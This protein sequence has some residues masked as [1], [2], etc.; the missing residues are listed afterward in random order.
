MLVAQSWISLHVAPGSAFSTPATMI[1]GNRLGL[2]LICFP[3]PPFARAR[4]LF[5]FPSNSHATFKTYP[6]PQLQ[7]FTL[8]NGTFSVLPFLILLFGH[9][10]DQCAF[11]VMFLF[12]CFCINPFLPPSPFPHRNVVRMI[13]PF[14][15]SCAG[16]GDFGHRSPHVC[17]YPDA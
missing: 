5:K 16:P 8:S 10:G 1:A 2:P 4:G 13:P 15:C 12:L 3:Y 11:D 17:F 14:R 6:P 7:S 9:L